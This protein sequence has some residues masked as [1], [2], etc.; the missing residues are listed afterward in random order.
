MVRLALNK[1]VIKALQESNQEPKNLSIAELALAEQEV[2]KFRKKFLKIENKEE[3]INKAEKDEVIMDF[4]LTEGLLE[5]MYLHYLNNP[6]EK[7]DRKKEKEE[8]KLR[9]ELTLNELVQ[10]REKR[11]AMKAFPSLWE[12]VEGAERGTIELTY[13]VIKKLLNQISF[14]LEDLDNFDLLPSDK[15]QLRLAFN[16]KELITKEEN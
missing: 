15:N 4:N 1:K 16:L 3:V 8:K 5:K 13:Q 2:L 12:N 10:Y 9:E 14:T 6:V 11:L 7:K